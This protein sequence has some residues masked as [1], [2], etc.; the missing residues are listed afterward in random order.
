MSDINIGDYVRDAAQR[1][2]HGEVIKIYT[3]NEHKYVRI[4]THQGFY[5]AIIMKNVILLHSSRK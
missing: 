5:P 3:S 2:D 1:E 4:K